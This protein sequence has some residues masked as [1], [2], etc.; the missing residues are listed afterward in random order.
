LTTNKPFTEWNEV[1]PSSGCI[2]TLIDRLIHKAEI[3]K[4][5]AESYR[6]KEARERAESRSK[7]RKRKSKRSAKTSARKRSVPD[8]AH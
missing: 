4:I 5:A 8:G 7:Q 2:V 1:F 3:V 6:L